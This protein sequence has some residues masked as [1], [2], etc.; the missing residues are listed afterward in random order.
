VL[1]IDDEESIRS[2]LKDMLGD[3]G[4][5]VRTAADGRQGLQ[6]I[7]VWAPDV[8][9]LD[10]SMPVMGG[11]AF[12]EAQLGLPQ[13]LRDVPIIA[14]TGARN[15]E[16]QARAIGAVAVLSKPF[17]LNELEQAVDKAVGGLPRS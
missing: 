2:A 5:E 11:R 3:E 13:A 4:H 17:D 15:A 14:L 7:E 9:L 1:V 16:E 10:L 6:I 8:I 12:R